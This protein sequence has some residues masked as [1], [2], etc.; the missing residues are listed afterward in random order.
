[1]AAERKGMKTWVCVLDT[2]PTLA[3]EQVHWTHVFRLKLVGSK[4]CRKGLVE[5]NHLGNAPRNHGEKGGAGEEEL[6]PQVTLRGP[7]PPNRPELPGVRMNPLM[8]MALSHV[9]GEASTLD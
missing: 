9:A 3:G 4:G 5:K 6:S 1:M 7:T 2:T 8:S